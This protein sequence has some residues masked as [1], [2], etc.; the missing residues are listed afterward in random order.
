MISWRNGHIHC[1]REEI[2]AYRVYNPLINKIMESGDIL[3]SEERLA[4]RVRKQSKKY[5]FVD[6][7]ETKKLTTR[8]FTTCVTT[9]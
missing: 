7:V 1:L 8:L 9:N 6:E 3:V 4:N 2:K 5:Q